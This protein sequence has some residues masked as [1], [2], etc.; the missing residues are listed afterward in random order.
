MMPF[1]QLAAVF[2]L[3][4][5]ASQLP[6]FE[7]DPEFNASEILPAS[8]LHSDDHKV[9]ETV[10]NDGFMNQYVVE[11]SF[12][13]FEADGNRQLSRRIQESR[14]LAELDQVT[15]SDLYLDAAK[16]VVTAPVKAVGKFVDA[17]AETVKGIP[18]G[19]S[20]KF[21]SIGR[22]VKRGA[23]A[24]KEEVTED[25]T[26]EEASE[27]E[28]TTD[29]K[30]AP[31]EQADADQESE[32]KTKKYAL[33]WFGVTGAERRWAQKLAIDPYS[34]NT[35]L[36]EKISAVA[37]VDAA[38]S[39]GAKLLMP[40]LGA[41]SYVVTVS[42]LVWSLDGEELR[43]Y[44]LK[45]LVEAG[46]AREA[47]DTF[48]DNPIFSP[49]QQTV[50]VQAMVLMKEANGLENVLTVPEWVDE[51]EEAWFYANTIHLIS[52][53]HQSVSPVEAISVNPLLP[54]LMTE[55]DVTVFVVPVDYLTWNQTLA[56]LLAGPLAGAEGSEKSIW[57]EGQA[58]KTAVSAL[59]NLGWS[60]E[61]G[62]LLD[63][64]DDQASP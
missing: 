52:R 20:R 43:A 61:A 58:T 42:N 15:K 11:T 32:S 64:I 62:V 53:F 38:A 46:V 23:K 30:A 28:S 49:T 3:L 14:A 35:V 12:G 37:K 45:Q 60:V 51:G 50:I 40:G 5:T 13:N 2:V 41:V 24:V 8:Q 36:R 4:A 19:V 6:G 29:E 27:E 54:G 31:E 7:P 26:E 55:D 57:I 47:I 25:D 21:R 16:R 9:R 63:K 18:G 34:D 22:S 33:K 10:V 17:P 44:N 1:S 56:D 39:F 48:L 59:A